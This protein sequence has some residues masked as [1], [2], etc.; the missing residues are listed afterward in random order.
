LSYSSHLFFAKA[1]T[2]DEGRQEN[3]KAKIGRLASQ[4]PSTQLAELA[5]AD[6]VE[7]YINGL[8]A[9]FENEVFTTL[10]VPCMFDSVLV[11]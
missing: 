1:R 9:R 8:E 7:I 6:I 3:G 2:K 5:A 11:L 10:Q 4:Q